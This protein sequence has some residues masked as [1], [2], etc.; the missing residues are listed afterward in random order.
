MA[1][2]LVHSSDVTLF[3]GDLHHVGPGD[4]EFGRPGDLS[5]WATPDGAITL[6]WRGLDD[7]PEDAKLIIVQP[8]IAVRLAHRLRLLSAEILTALQA[9]LEG[10]GNG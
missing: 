1:I 9:E 8:M 10:G 7:P 5:A 2:K 4:D 3:P 6:C